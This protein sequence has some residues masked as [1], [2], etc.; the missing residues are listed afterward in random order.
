MSPET[1]T[2]GR[3]VMREAYQHAWSKDLQRACGWEDE[4]NAMLVWGL[5]APKEAAVQWQDLLD[6]DGG[7]GR[8]DKKTGQW[9]SY[10]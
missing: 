9:V 8:W 2:L 4:G 5:E 1:A 6:T 7:R 10:Y 3:A